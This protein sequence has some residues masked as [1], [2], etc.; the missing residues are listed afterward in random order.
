M[1]NNI[2][3]HTKNIVEHKKWVFHYACKAGIPIQGLTH[4]LSKFSPTEFI[5]AIQYYK[6][7]ISPLKE[8]KRVNGYSLAKLHHCHHNKHHYEYWQDEFDKGGKPLI[9]PF[10]YA[11]EL[12]CDY[13]AA[14]RIYFKDN[15][16]NSC[17]NKN[18][19]SIESIVNDVLIELNDKNINTKT[20]VLNTDKSSLVA[21]D[22]KSIASKLNYLTTESSLINN[23]INPNNKYWKLNAKLSSL[24]HSCCI[25]KLP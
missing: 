22:E 21:I 14:G 15:V 10:N 12:I 23:S 3:N 13:L 6:E 9:M 1:I 4:D 19:K 5:E 16:N 2:I 20:I 17:A 7:G 8:S 18:R 25:N 24:L 11:L